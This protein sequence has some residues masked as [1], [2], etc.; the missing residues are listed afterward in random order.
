[1]GVGFAGNYAP[2]AVA[3]EHRIKGSVVWG[4]LCDAL[5]DLHDRYP[6][7]RPQLRWIVGAASR[8]EAR[9]QYKPFI[10]DGL[11]Q[12][13]E[14]PV[15][16]THGARDR[17]VP[18][19]AAERIYREPTVEDGE[20]RVYHDD[21][22]GAEH[23]SMDSW[24]QVIPDRV[25]WLPDRIRSPRRLGSNGRSPGNATGEQAPPPC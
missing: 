5:A 22:G 23:C 14:C 21:E 8:E 10:L 9:K 7:L 6:R 4:A 12:K 25:D 24:T 1:M 19:S 3:F 2:G 16:I 11:P 15:L 20:L 17:M 18:L 13:A